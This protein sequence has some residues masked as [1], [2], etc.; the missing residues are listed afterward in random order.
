MDVCD[1]FI[2]LSSNVTAAGPELVQE[3][4]LPNDHCQT[5]SGGNILLQLLEFKTHLLEVVEELHIRRDAEARFEDQISKLMLEK[6]ELEW[7]KE[8]L[9]HQIETGENQHAESLSKTNKEFQAKIRNIEEEK[10]RYQVNAELKDKEI[11]NLKE[12][13]K[14][15]QLLKYNLEKKSSEL[16]HKLTLQSRSKDSHLNQ[17]GEVEKRFSALSRQCA[18]VK[19][20]HE[21]LELN[22][23]EAMKLNKKLTSTNEKHEI[24]ITSLNKELEEL[25]NKLVKTKMPS[26]SYTKSDVN[27]TIREQ[28]IKQLHQKLTMEQEMNRKLSGENKALQTEKQEVLRSLQLAHQLLLDQTQTVSRLELDLQ[29]QRHQHQSLEEDLKTMQ[30]KE[31]VA[32]E[33]IKQLMEEYA[34][35]KTSWDKEK[36]EII[37]RTK[38]EKQELVTV[39]RAFE[40]L[41]QKHNSLSSQAIEQAQQI[42]ELKMKV[43]DQNPNVSAPSNSS[44]EGG[45]SKDMTIK[46]VLH[47]PLSNNVQALLLAKVSDGP[48]DTEDTIATGERAAPTM[49]NES[50]SEVL[51]SNNCQSSNILCSCS[52]ATILSENMSN[53]TNSCTMNGDGPVTKSLSAE[54]VVKSRNTYLRSSVTSS[55]NNDSSSVTLITEN[56]LENTETE[57]KKD[58]HSIKISNYKDEEKKNEKDECEG[59]TDK[60]KVAEETESPFKEEKGDEMDRQNEREEIMDV[61]LDMHIFETETADKEE[62]RDG[63]SDALE[64]ER[65]PQTTGDKN[66]ADETKRDDTQVSHFSDKEPQ[67]ASHGFSE[68][69][70]QAPP[71]QEI[72][73]KELLPEDFK[74]SQVCESNTSH[75]QRNTAE[76]LPS[77]V[78]HD[79]EE[80]PEMMCEQSTT[81]E[82]PEKL[83]KSRLCHPQTDVAQLDV[84][85]VQE[86]IKTQT[87][88]V[89]HPDTPD[90]MKDTVD[91]RAKECPLVNQRVDDPTYLQSQDGIPEIK[92]CLVNSVASDT[93]C[94][95][96]NILTDISENNDS[97][98]TAVLDKSNLKRKQPCDIMENVEDTESHAHFDNQPLKI[99]THDT[100]SNQSESDIQTTSSKSPPFKTPYRSSFEWGTAQRRVPSYATSYKPNFSSLDGSFTTSQMSQLNTTGFIGHSSSLVPMFPKSKYSKVPLVITRATDLLNASS[101]CGTAASSKR[102]QPGEWRAIGEAHRETGAMESR[103]PQSVASFSVPASSGIVNRPS[104]QTITE[105]PSSDASPDFECEP[106]CSQDTEDQQ[107]SFRVQISKI[108]QFLNTERLR[109][110]KRRKTEN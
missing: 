67:S 102:L 26:V 98:E 15:L 96:S 25:R 39:K 27:P 105:T 22:V 48:K 37:D 91:E 9:Q 13:L 72:T 19:H 12:E 46:N 66:Y 95:T 93:E 2:N 8:S 35:S 55:N 24:T 80:N 84:V 61:A 51:K 21:Q 32:I 79:L 108:E 87:Q 29:T 85:S 28:N 59:E 7:E 49:N 47:T 50:Q 30:E 71:K 99:V 107:S 11:T 106:S 16:E 76:A 4:S 90:H 110:P 41:H 75:I 81:S 74:E 5:K 42:H 38:D 62:T 83:N 58:D 77:P 20:T 69:F 60:G 100:M 65:H 94:T 53:Y 97:C 23:D 64:A 14:S 43:K 70:E 86:T 45:S 52:S 31:K 92:N 78:C 6:Q 63:N 109:L 101:V 36:A 103:I 3:L 44:L 88:V 18:M 73:R 82:L 33:E 54:S 57:I 89:S 68:K 104:R 10:G 56:M 34:V 40:E 1:K 17:L